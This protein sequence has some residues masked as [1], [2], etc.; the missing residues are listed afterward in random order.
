MEGLKP[1]MSWTNEK[2]VN[3][4]HLV[5]FGSDG[6]SVM[7]G[8]KSGVT[9]RMKA[10]NPFLVSVH[11]AATR[12]ALAS[13][14]V[15]KDI[16][17]LTKFM[18]MLHAIYNYFH[19]S[20]VRSAKLHAVQAALEEPVHSY[21][22]VFSV[23]AVEAVLRSW[24]VLQTTLGDEVVS[25][26]NPA[27]SGILKFTS[28]FIFL[29]TSFFLLDTLSVPK[30]VIK[31]FQKSDV[32]FSVVQPII[33]SAISSLEAQLVTPG[34]YLALFLATAGE[35]CEEYLECQI[36]DSRPQRTQFESLKKNFIEQLVVNMN[37]RFPDEDL[38][39]LNAMTILDMERLPSADGL[40]EHG[41]EK[42]ELLLDHYGKER[43]RRAPL[44]DSDT[45]QRNG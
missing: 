7:V 37:K 18:E 5:G 25:S 27:A 12:L 14:Q 9:T 1:V 8:S 39:L 33:Q 24:P 36:T 6:A 13:S 41:V 30:T 16:T 32:D 38:S 17:Y 42:L 20:A 22:E 23:N 2:K 43:G 28:Q 26:S 35:S 11:C 21:K 3:L 4:V 15:T 29:A 31:V 34:P 45:F 44:L 19:N 10:L 40:A